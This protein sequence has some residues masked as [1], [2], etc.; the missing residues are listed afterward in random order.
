MIA[1]SSAA[2]EADF[3]TPTQIR[4]KDGSDIID[5]TGLYDEAATEYPTEHASVRSKTPQITVATSS[6]TFD[7][8]EGDLIDQD[9][10]NYEIL[11]VLSDDF[12]TVFA[13]NDIT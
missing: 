4:K 2:V 8:G 9:G 1:E 13:V 11:D 7:Y 3:G 12:I 6:L 10:R 5:V